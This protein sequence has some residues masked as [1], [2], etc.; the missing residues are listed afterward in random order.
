MVAIGIK[1]LE[2]HPASNEFQFWLLAFYLV[3]G[4]VQTVTLFLALIAPLSLNSTKFCFNYCCVPFFSRPV[5]SF[6]PFGS[7]NPGILE[8]AGWT[9]DKAVF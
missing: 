9:M 2:G 4:K 8:S 7:R 5:P 1:M 3:S 6:S